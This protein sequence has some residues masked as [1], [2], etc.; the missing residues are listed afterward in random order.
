MATH[1][2]REMAIP[3]PRA[4]ATLSQATEIQLATLL[5]MDPAMAL[6]A[7]TLQRKSLFEHQDKPDE[8]A[9]G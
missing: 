5:L 7:A 9:A 3:A 8:Q 1:L 4:M 6:E 2:Q